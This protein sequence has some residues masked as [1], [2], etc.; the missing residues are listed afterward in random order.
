MLLH[1][2]A[3]QQPCPRWHA[4]DLLPVTIAILFAAQ[5]SDGRYLM[6]NVRRELQG[7]DMSGMTFLLLTSNHYQT[8]FF[9]PNTTLNLVKVDGNGL[10]V[11]YMVDL[12][13]ECTVQLP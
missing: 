1:S 9:P 7:S 13:G 10:S 2:N 12:Q 4:E 3:S 6:L 11:N 5:S 8:V